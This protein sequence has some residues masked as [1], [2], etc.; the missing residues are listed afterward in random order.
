MKK[1]LFLL[2]ILLSTLCLT[3]CGGGTQF[4][5]TERPDAEGPVIRLSDMYY[6]AV[7]R[8]GEIEKGGISTGA[9]YEYDSRG[10]VTMQAVYDERGRKDWICTYEYD[11]AGLLVG[12][13]ECRTGKDDMSCKV[14]ENGNCRM[15]DRPDFKIR[16]TIENRTVS[17]FKNDSLVARTTYDA[18]G[19]ITVLEDIEGGSTQTFTYD[20]RGLSSFRLTDKTDDLVFTVKPVEFDSRGNWTKAY[21]SYMGEVFFVRERAITYAK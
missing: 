13:T 15:F 12:Y 7:D 11:D 5:L 18:R 14:T 8:Y 6:I 21:M 1:T 16:R 3:A 4:S 9:V 17:E 10:L 19:R 20:E 2:T